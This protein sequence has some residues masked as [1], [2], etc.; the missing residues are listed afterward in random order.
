MMRKIKLS[1]PAAWAIGTLAIGL[2]LTVLTAWQLSVRNA[3]TLRNATSQSARHALSSIAQRIEL[4]Q[5]GLRGARGAVI[6]AGEHGISRELFHRYSLS[7]DIAREF[8]GARGFGF[9]RRVADAELPAFIA[10]ARQTGDPGF[11]LRQLQPFRGEHAIVQ[12]IEPENRNS[13]AIGLDIASDPERRRTAM[14]ALRTGDIQLT[15]PILLQQGAQQPQQGFLMLLPTYRSHNTPDKESAR[16]TEG[17][18]WSYASLIISEALGSLNLDRDKS[19]I[20]LSDVTDP[21]HPIAFFTSGKPLPNAQVVARETLR[22]PLFGRTWQIGFSAYPPF[23]AELN[24]PSVGMI[25]LAGALLSLISAALAHAWRANARSQHRLIS[26]QEDLAAIVDS[27]TDAII[28]KTLNGEVVSWNKGAQE[29]FGYSAG[30]AIGR[31]LPQLIVPQDRQTEETEILARVSKGERISHLQT[32][33]Q[34]KDGRLVDVSVSVSPIYD[35]ASKV[36]G[37]SKTVRDITHQKVMEGQ[38]LALN[39]MAERTQALEKA[40]HDLR[41]ILDA[42]PSMIGYW[43]RE[44]INRV[45]NHAYHVWF[46]KPPGTL[47]GTRMQDLL[48]AEAFEVS[49]PHLEATLRGEAQQFERT[50]PNPDGQFRHTLV[51]YLPDMVDGAVCGFYTVVHDVSELVDSRTRLAAALREN[52]VLLSSIN[53]QLLYSATDADG[54]I[55][56]AN[57][58]FCAAC[59]YS[60]EELTGQDHRI[61]QSGIHDR[62]FWQ[63]MWE[64]L[65][66]GQAWHGEICNQAKDGSLRWSD[67]VIA[68]LPDHDGAIERIVALRIDTTRRKLVDEEINRLS[69]LLSNVLRAASEVS[70]IATDAHG[71]ITVF[72]TGAERMLGYDQQEVVGLHTP[73]IFHLAEEMEQRSQQ[74]SRQYGMP[75][76]GFRSFVHEPETLG[77]ETREW[78]YVRKDGGHIA[79]SLVVTA[80]H[81]GNGAIGGYVGIATDITERRRFETQMVQA[82]QQAEQASMAKSQFLANMSHEIRTPMNAVL[83]LLQLLLHTQLDY[84]QQDYVDK[85]Q[86]AAKSLLGILNDILDFSKIEAGKLQLDL[87]PFPLDELLRDLGVILSGNH[88]EKDVE[89]IFEIDPSLPTAVVGDR[90][91]LQQILIN[92]AGNAMKFTEQG[93]VIVSVSSP[94]R[95][96]AKATLHF[97]VTDTGIGISP[98]QLERIFDGFTQAEACTARRFGGT[99]LG[100][101]ICQRLVRMM[102]GHLRASSEPGHGSRFWF[103]ITLDIADQAPVSAAPGQ[104]KLHVLAVDDNPL[105]GEI[106]TQTIAAAGWSADYAGSGVQAIQAAQ[107][108]MARGAPYDAVLMDWRMP[109]MDG[110]SAAAA[111]RDAT[112]GGKPPAVIMVTAFG[113]EV[114]SEI[115]D[116]QDTPFSDFLTKPLTPQQLIDAVHR[117]IHH[118]NPRPPAGP[119]KPARK[120]AGMKL[121]LVEDNAL[122]RQIAAELCRAEGA[123]IVLA[124]GGLEGVNIATR[125]DADFDVIIMDMQMPDIDGLEAT[126]RIRASRF[127][128]ATPILAMTANATVADRDACLEAGM[129]DHIGK[130]I[131]MNEVVPRLLALAGTPEAAPPPAI[132]PP[133]DAAGQDIEP[134]E[135]V[136]SRLGQRMEVLQSALANFQPEANRLTSILKRNAE[137]GAASRMAAPL[138]ALRGIA[139]TVGATTLARY[140]SRLE[141]Y[142]QSSATQPFDAGLWLNA[143]NTL[144]QLVTESVDKLSARMPPPASA[145]PSPPLSPAEWRAQLRAMLPLLESGNLDA[146][147]HAAALLSLSEDKVKPQL[148][149]LVEQVRRLQFA[150]AAQII[151][152]LME[153]EP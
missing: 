86:T 58:A 73:A 102:G 142:A 74:L 148:H 99:G 132:A 81:D 70:I 22:H 146:I 21:A 88:G 112:R 126:R 85:I 101:V 139:A 149:D 55:V 153:S 24:L 40:Q 84:R 61:L 18:G 63:T 80:I 79:V 11:A 75:I 69:L 6:T 39:S 19:Q 30:E 23:E 131:D 47:P 118:Q 35:D 150:P 43:D 91:R 143:A 1:S 116:L 83:G 145:A 78:T 121:L 76:T 141:Q 51:H 38:L 53:E 124:E 94:A 119:V 54:R 133:E 66:Q 44:L 122:N 151:K 147:D 90:L 113:R 56:D 36:I 28:G 64:T 57:E 137:S 67:T 96:D 8:P 117:A 60:R 144:H 104:E 107:D 41:T 16:L 120:L 10:A 27:S 103:D 37:V 42:V 136:L 111:I 100:L 98:E 140:A 14:T 17:F 45:A 82:R 33:W 127:G 34:R 77:S 20:A 65:R 130:P 95:D 138:H 134:E 114:L 71:L 135:Q 7:R 97:A 152:T 89:A 109:D 93:Q 12:F 52:Q 87:H 46:G 68:P 50:I 9:I 62:A 15:E 48:S 129:N 72:N 13:R 115:A 125:P 31:P 59:G 26:A 3:E 29:I 106:L 108:A 2:L 25:S 110:V 123:E 49:L 105:T 5:Y 128:N 4:Y 32:V 92:L